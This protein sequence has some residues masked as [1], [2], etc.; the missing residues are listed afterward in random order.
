MRAIPPEESQ[1]GKKSVP[2]NFGAAQWRVGLKKRKIL[3]GSLWLV[4]VTGLAFPAA[5][6]PGELVA[7]LPQVLN[8]FFITIADGRLYIVEN[9]STAHIYTI[10]AKGVAFVKTFGRAGQGPGEFDFMYLIRVFKDHL[11]IPGSNKLARF[12]L[13][14]E[15][16][17][18][19][20]FPI[21][22]FKGGI[23]RLG[24]NFVTRDFQF[25]DKGATT[26]IRLSDKD[27]K[28][29]KEIGARKT[30]M[31]L[32]KLN[33]VA[34][35]F[36]P[37]V[38]GDQIFIISSGRESVVAVYDR[39]GI[40]QKEIRLPLEPVRMTAALKEAIIKP[41]R[42][43]RERMTSWQE[44]EKRLFFPD[45]TPGLDY[46]DVIEGKFV[47]RTYKYRQDSVEF[48]IFDQQGRELRRAALPFTG[49]ISNGILFCFYQG[50]YF[51]LRENAG[52]EIWEL[53]SE[54]VW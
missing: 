21:S 24:Q 51:Y 16:I 46:F 6:A 15:Y 48:V 25:D 28:L 42:E 23:Y 44:Y 37:R 22:V 27:F 20:K 9:S 45:Q 8:P 7:K 35:Y 53:H 17:N 52:E 2:I 54:K 43:D 26:T 31:G 49:R 29:I 32:E 36:S 10:G 14:G 12:S 4:I 40:R 39:N 1:G 11:D 13:D 50:R 5:P 33:L 38:V 30:A 18:E 34:D 3:L 47:A 41:I 19:V